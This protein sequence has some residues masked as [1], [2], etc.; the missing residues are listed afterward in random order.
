[1]I[2]RSPAALLCAQPTNV[3]CGVSPPHAHGAA[4]RKTAAAKCGSLSFLTRVQTFLL[5]VPSD[6]T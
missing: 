3:G 6:T 5:T 2:F 1:M 4:V